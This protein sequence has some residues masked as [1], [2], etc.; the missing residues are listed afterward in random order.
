MNEQHY[1][2]QDRASTVALRGKNPPIP[3]ADSS[4]NNHRTCFTALA[5]NDLLRDAG[6]NFRMLSTV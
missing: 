3:P 6:A 4:I 5:V 2:P 1:D